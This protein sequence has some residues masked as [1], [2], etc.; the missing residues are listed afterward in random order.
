MTALTAQD[1]RELREWRIK[2]VRK[3][4]DGALQAMERALREAERRHLPID[5]EWRA[6]TDELRSRFL[7]DPGMINAA[8]EHEV[9]RAR[10]QGEN[11]DECSD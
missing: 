8:W 3:Q 10:K 7:T 1:K 6:R 2:R 9:S 11:H 5:P 4:V